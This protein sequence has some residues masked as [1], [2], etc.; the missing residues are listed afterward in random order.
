MAILFKSP[1]W[2]LTSVVDGLE[3]LLPL[4]SGLRYELI[5]QL[6]ADPELANVSES[7]LSE[8]IGEVIRPYVN[9]QEYLHGMC[10]SE[11]RCYLSGEVA[12]KIKPREKR[13][14]KKKLE[15]MR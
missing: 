9:S 5:G 8:A 6:R 3:I 4:A 12:S 7:D 13:W 15:M 10:V 14:A 1:I 11:S 2:G